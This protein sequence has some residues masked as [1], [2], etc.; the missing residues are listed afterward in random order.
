MTSIAVAPP[1]QSAGVGSVPAG[2]VPE[3]V[4]PASNTEQPSGGSASAQEAARQAEER[5]AAQRQAAVQ[6]AQADHGGGSILDRSTR[7]DIEVQQD[8]GLL[9]KV[10][11]AKTDKVVREIPPEELVEF[12]RKLKRYLGLLLDKRA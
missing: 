3:V 1:A 11:D 4:R 9:V 2:A 5:Q 12:G 8:G 10:R 7:L 6:R